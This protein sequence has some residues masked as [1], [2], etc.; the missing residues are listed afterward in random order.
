M[1]AYIIANIL[2]KDEALM[3]KY[4]DRDK[5]ERDDIV[6]FYIYRLLR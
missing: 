4:A 2:I 5:G 3:Q 1:S 6:N